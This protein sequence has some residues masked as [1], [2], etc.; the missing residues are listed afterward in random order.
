MR[1]HEKQE[2]LEIT[3][4]LVVGEHAAVDVRQ[5]DGSIKTVTVVELGKLDGLTATA[6]ELNRAA[7]VS[8]RL[9]TVTGT[10]LS[11]T[12]DSHDG[13][14]IVMSEDGGDNQATFTLPDASG[15]GA[16]FHFKVGVVNTS[17]YVIQAA[18]ADDTMAGSV[19]MNQD[20]GDSVVS[21][22]T[23][24]SDDTITLNG[25]TQGGAAVGDWIELEDIADNTWAVRGV[26]TGT[27]TE[28]TPF[29]AAV[30]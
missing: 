16:K 3:R 20:S 2:L 22:N 9:V 7:D 13:K 15:S 5:A 28:A 6:T 1:L 10:S 11:V 8:G 24:S 14:T 4:N 19:I 17:N 21:F 25:G 23:S 27:G 18:N 29:S 30:S 12:Q 26:L